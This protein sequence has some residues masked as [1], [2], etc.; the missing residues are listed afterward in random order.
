MTEPTE[1]AEAPAR[2][3]GRLA[4]LV[5]VPVVLVVGFV[6]VVLATSEP[7]ANRITDSPLLGRGAPEIVGE[8]VDG[9][10]FRLSDLQGRFVIV[11]FFATW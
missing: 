10:P 5:V 7:A 8:T 1:P 3:P 6:V 2:R 9:A 11:N 4:L